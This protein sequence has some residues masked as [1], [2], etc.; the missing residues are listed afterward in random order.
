MYFRFGFDINS[1]DSADSGIQSDTRSDDGLNPVNGQVNE[2]I[3][4][5]VCKSTSS[6]LGIL[7][8]ETSG[9]ESDST[10]TEEV[11]M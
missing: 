7:H 3:Y 11:I 6:E 1:P 2:D 8:I 10:P 5:A 9:S 4:A